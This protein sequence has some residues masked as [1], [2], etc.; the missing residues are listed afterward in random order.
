MFP[1]KSDGKKQENTPKK[2]ILW[3]MPGGSKWTVRKIRARTDL[4]K[5]EGVAGRARRSSGLHVLYRCRGRVW[6]P[7]D[8][9]LT[10]R[11][12][13]FQEAG[14]RNSQ[15]P[16]GRTPTRIGGNLVLTEGNGGGILQ[17]TP[18]SQNTPYSALGFPKGSSMCMH[19]LPFASYTPC[20][21]L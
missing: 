8:A 4:A 14:T 7:E 3:S 21:T 1:K 17:T 13:C 2:H 15:S 16:S 19:V 18:S 10:V 11:T 12:S 5:V 9:G 6:T 20:A